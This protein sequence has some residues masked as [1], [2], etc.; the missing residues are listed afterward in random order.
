MMKKTLS[1]IICSMLYWSAH[2]Q[3]A[4]LRK[5]EIPDGKNAVDFALVDPNFKDSFIFLK[6]S[7]KSFSKTVYEVSLIDS[8]SLQ[9]KKKTVMPSYDNYEILRPRPQNYLGFLPNESVE[10]INRSIGLDQNMVWLYYSKAGKREA[11]SAVKVDESL[12]FPE[13]PTYLFT[14]DD[15]YDGVLISTNH[16]KN[17]CVLSNERKDKKSKTST[18]YYRVYDSNMN[19]LKADSAISDL[20]DQD[21][22]KAMAYD[23][24]VVLIKNK[25]KKRLITVYDVRNNSENKFEVEKGSNIMDVE[26][27]RL[28]ANDKIVFL[29]TY[30]ANV[31]RKSTTKGVFKVVYNQKSKTVEQ[32]VFFDHVPVGKNEAEN[33]PKYVVE[34]LITETGGC[35]VLVSQITFFLPNKFEILYVNN[36]TEKWKKQLPIPSPAAG[37]DRASLVPN[38]SVKM[39]FTNGNLFITYMNFN[40]TALPDI[41]NYVYGEPTPERPKSYNDTRAS[42]DVLKIDAKGNIQLQKF[43]QTYYTNA[44]TH[45]SEIFAIQPDPKEPKLLS[46]ALA[47]E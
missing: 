18:F 23:N 44:I 35:Y 45:G 21:T 17:I 3:M 8:R 11:I 5:S 43:P 36:E 14:V 10:Y 19:L 34:P 29:G 26:A 15:H 38:Y 2:A 4:T 6:S 16:K 13:K 41:N 25:G 40:E 46:I 37:S 28:I 27:I 22:L 7:A 20:K 33:E 32:Q 12:T 42:A 9:E 47:G 1:L 31:T 24:G 30:Y 39:T